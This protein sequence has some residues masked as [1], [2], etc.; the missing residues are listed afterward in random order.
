[1][2]Y[3]ISK[4]LSHSRVGLSAVVDLQLRSMGPLKHSLHCFR[5][6]LDEAWKVWLPVSLWYHL[7]FRDLCLNMFTTTDS[8]IIRFILP[9]FKP[10]FSYD[11]RSNISLSSSFSS[12]IM[13][14]DYEVVSNLHSK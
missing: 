5:L 6:N 8:H 2:K 14:K 11:K 12:I 7:W 1:M 9:S 4:Y 3:R 13:Q 10:E